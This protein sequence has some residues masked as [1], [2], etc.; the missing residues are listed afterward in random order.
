LHELAL[1]EEKWA[2]FVGFL[3]RYLIGFW[4]NMWTEDLRN[5]LAIFLLLQCQFMQ[6]INRACA[7][8][9]SPTLW[10]RILDMHSV[11][12]QIFGIHSVKGQILGMHS[13]KGQFFG[14]HNVRGRILGFKLSISINSRA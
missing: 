9:S 12:G 3:I 6:G 10:G 11:K 13:V 7:R 4:A 2:L 14:V 1:E 5:L 8:R